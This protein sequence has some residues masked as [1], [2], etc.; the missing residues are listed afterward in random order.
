MFFFLLVK[1]YRDNHIE[2]WVVSYTKR[3]LYYCYDHSFKQIAKKF[4]LNQKF[5]PFLGASLKP[6][7][8]GFFT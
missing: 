7:K 1:T 8:K 6:E 2:I 5:K 3:K 4:K